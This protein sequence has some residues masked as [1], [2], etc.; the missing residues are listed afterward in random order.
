MDPNTFTD[1]RWGLIQ[2]TYTWLKVPTVTDTKSKDSYRYWY[3][4]M[5]EYS[6]RYWFHISIVLT[7]LSISIHVSRLLP[8]PYRTKY[9]ILI[10]LPKQLT[11]SDIGISKY[12][13]SIQNEVLKNKHKF[14]QKVAMKNIFLISH[15]F[16]IHFKH[17]LSASNEI[18]QGKWSLTVVNRGKMGLN[19]VKL[20]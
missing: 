7:I 6:N 12:I 11:N 3:P 15:I 4:Y 19:W 20:S 5:S 9:K 16:P 2:I 18:K 10:L 17:N 1:T 14:V 8:I 13:G